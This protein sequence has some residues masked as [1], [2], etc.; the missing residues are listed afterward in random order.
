MQ[1]IKW[2]MKVNSSLYL[3]AWGIRC[4]SFDDLLDLPVSP[5]N[6][7]QSKYT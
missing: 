6:N 2:N 7:N 1:K 5:P 3:L 4:L